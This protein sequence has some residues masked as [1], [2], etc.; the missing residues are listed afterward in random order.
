MNAIWGFLITCFLL[1][2]VFAVETSY[3][4]FP[5]PD[6][7]NCIQESSFWVCKSPE[8]KINKQSYI[9]IKAK[10]VG[11][12]ETLDSLY[13]FLSKPIPINQAVAKNILSQVKFAEFKIHN[14]Q[15]W[16]LAR[17]LHSVLDNYYTDYLVTVKGDLSIS[18]EINY[19]EKGFN[20]FQDIQSKVL[21]NVQLKENAATQNISQ[22]KAEIQSD[23]LPETNSN[24]IESEN[25]DSKRKS[26]WLYVIIGLVV[27]MLGWL[28][29][30]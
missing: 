27:I 7:W 10:L 24:N 19:H 9:I 22:N 2:K 8:S 11:K 20:L 28:I 16:I 6:G 18:I 1:S 12:S 25:S 13:Q 26:L 4:K 17:H 23:P 15:K 21:S 3:L 5:E 30:L 29:R 14:N